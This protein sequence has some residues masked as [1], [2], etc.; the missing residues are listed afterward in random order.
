MKLSGVNCWRGGESLL[1]MF[2]LIFLPAMLVFPLLLR[3][4]VSFFPVS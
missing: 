2:L 1:R 4:T 3:T